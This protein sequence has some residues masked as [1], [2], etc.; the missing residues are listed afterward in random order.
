MV[1]SHDLIFFIE[2]IYFFKKI[3]NPSRNQSK[4]WVG[5]PIQPTRAFGLGQQKSDPTRPDP[6]LI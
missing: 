2:F 3:D 6:I 4:G 5:L 1:M